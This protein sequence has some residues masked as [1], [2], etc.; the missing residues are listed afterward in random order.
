MDV[1]ESKQYRDTLARKLKELR[2]TDRKKA[3]NV[4][5]IAKKTKKYREARKILLNQRKNKIK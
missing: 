5:S 1:Y 3:M 4:L 2:K